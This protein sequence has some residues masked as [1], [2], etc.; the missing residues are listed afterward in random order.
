MGDNSDG[1]FLQA[2]R[3][4]LIGFYKLYDPI[5]ANSITLSAID[6]ISGMLLEQDD[7]IRDMKL[8][9]CSR[10][11]PNYLRSKTGCA[12]AYA[13][14]LFPKTMSL[15]LAT[16]ISVIEDIAFFTNAVNDILS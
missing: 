13:F 9:D 4:H 16:Y 14:M 8:S 12:E 15:D 10:S 1:N 7:A 2:F 3:K 6:C 11:W 5:P